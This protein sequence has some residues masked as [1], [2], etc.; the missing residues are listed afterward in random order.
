MNVILRSPS[1][2]LRINSATKNLVL[3]ERFF[4]SA[5]LRLRMTHSSAS[6][7]LS[8]KP[9]C[10]TFVHFTMQL[11]RTVILSAAKNLMPRPFASGGV[12]QVVEKCLPS[13]PAVHH[14]C[15]F[16]CGLLL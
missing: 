7:G 8:T 9:E 12:C 11:F 4:A 1:T 14:K 3:A 15:C 13:S 5:V 10:K 2:P 16:L 6:G